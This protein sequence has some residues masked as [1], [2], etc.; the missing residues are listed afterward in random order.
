M[1]IYTSN[2]NNDLRL[3]SLFSIFFQFSTISIMNVL[4]YSKN[5]KRKEYLLQLFI[6]PKIHNTYDIHDLI[7]D[8]HNNTVQLLVNMCLNI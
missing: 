7:Y 4:I 8:T 1:A 3:S 5:K 6:V 2:L